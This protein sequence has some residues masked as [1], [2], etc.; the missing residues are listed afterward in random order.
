MPPLCLGVQTE[1]Q[2]TYSR[3]GIWFPTCKFFLHSQ[4][5]IIIIN[6]ILPKDYI[7]NPQVF[8]NRGFMLDSKN[9]GIEMLFLILLWTFWEKK[10]S[11]LVVIDLFTWPLGKNDENI[12]K[13]FLAA[14]EEALPKIRQSLANIKIWYS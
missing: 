13:I 12:L 6:R 1:D 4:D 7:M 11:R 14:V 2:A 8:T 10:N 9:L 3:Q 5:K